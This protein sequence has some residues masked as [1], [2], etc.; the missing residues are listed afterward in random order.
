MMSRG[1]CVLYILHTLLKD[2]FRS[3]QRHT[4]SA[5]LVVSAEH[6]QSTKII[7]Q[8]SQTHPACNICISRNIKCE[9]FDESIW[10]R[11]PT[12]DPRS[13]TDVGSEGEFVNPIL[14]SEDPA[15]DLN[16]RHDAGT[17][18]ATTSLAPL[19]VIDIKPSQ[20]ASGQTPLSSVACLN[21]RKVK[22]KV[23]LINQTPSGHWQA[24]AGRD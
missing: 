3:Q 13:P 2:S 9:Y 21:C 24:V 14:S 4:C 5:H 16:S 18:P 23:R 7:L 19:P 10:Q 17:K 12:G 11:T 8:C 20:L 6:V 1:L 22:A 15:E